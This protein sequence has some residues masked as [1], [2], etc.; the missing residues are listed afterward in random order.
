MRLADLPAEERRRVV[1]QLVE[2]GKLPKT[3]GRRWPRT[4]VLLPRKPKDFA[5]GVVR[6]LG[7]RRARAIQEALVT[8][9]QAEQEGKGASERMRLGN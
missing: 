9:I 7:L 5:A 6:L 1:K 3:G 8:A 4:K 2:T